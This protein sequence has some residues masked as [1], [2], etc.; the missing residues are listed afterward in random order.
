MTAGARYP[1]LLDTVHFVASW[2]S[3]YIQLADLGAYF[4]MRAWRAG[5]WKK[6]GAD[7]HYNHFIAPAVKAVRVYPPGYTPVPQYSDG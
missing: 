1:N 4:T 5:G 3:P 6:P 7:A 2:E